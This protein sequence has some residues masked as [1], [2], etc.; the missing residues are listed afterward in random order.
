[1]EDG[2]VEGGSVHSGQCC[3]LNGVKKEENEGA[4]RLREWRQSDFKRI[5]RLRS[6]GFI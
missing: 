6:V 4:W 5:E 2:G 3:V 1:M